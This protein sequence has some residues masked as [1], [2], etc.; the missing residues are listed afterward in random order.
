MPKEKKLYEIIFDKEEIGKNMNITISNLNSD[1][2]NIIIIK[3]YGFENHYPMLSS[4]NWDKILIEINKTTSI[5]IE[6][7][8]YKLEERQ[9]VENE[10]FIIYIANAYDEN[11]RP[12]FEEEKF[13]IKEINFNKNSFS[14]YSTFDFQVI[15]M[16]KGSS[17]IL[18]QSNKNKINYQITLCEYTSKDYYFITD[19]SNSNISQNVYY[20]YYNRTISYDIQNNEIMSH[21]LYMKY[22]DPYNIVFYYNFDNNVKSNL[23][24][25]SNGYENTINY[26]KALDEN[27]LQLKFSTYYNKYYKFYIIIAL[28]DDNNNLSSFNNY[29]YLTK[30]ITENINQNYCLKMIYHNDSRSSLTTEIDISNLEADINSTFV[31]NIINENLDDKKLEFNYAK[32]FI[33][34]FPKEI[35]LYKSYEF[36]LKE[37]NFFR[38]DVTDSN[39]IE[40]ILEMDCYYSSNYITINVEGPGI[41]SQYTKEGYTI[42]VKITLTKPGKIFFRF[43]YKDERDDNHGTFLV[44]PLKVTKDIII[45][46]NEKIYFSNDTFITDNSEKIYIYNVTNLTEDRLVYFDCSQITQFEICDI[47]SNNCNFVK[48]FYKFL[49]NKEYFI[50]VY[51]YSYSGK[52]TMEPYVFGVFN[53]ENIKL[54]N[55]LGVDKTNEPMIYLVEQKY[56]S[57]FYFVDINTEISFYD[58]ENYEKD[59]IIDKLPNIYFRDIWRETEDFDLRY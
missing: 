23:L 57:F 4:N 27:I 30:L 52:G 15:E 51:A 3:D 6:N 48:K 19:Y 49:V 59:G 37:K 12:Y 32:E 13:E 53:K 56:V 41:N 54:N 34:E 40:F 35:E 43:T 55:D 16:D 7:P 14:K 20:K 39:I 21:T 1:N 26:V 10:T 58:E 42:N 45:D 25:A 18:S 47:S 11:G 9:L 50:N 36:A 22:G 17:V 8:Y 28:V 33:P 38:L 29:C 44:F 46:F 31:M 2:E 5:F 24:S